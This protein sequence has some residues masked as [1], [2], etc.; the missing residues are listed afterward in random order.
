MSTIT[1]LYR[2]RQASSVASCTPQA[3]V[4]INC[5]MLEC[6]CRPRFFAGQVLQADDLNRL[7]AY[8]RA[9]NRL[10]N[11]QL[12]GWGVVNG[13]EV[14]CNPCG[15]GVTV[16]C[17]YALSPCGEDIVV[18]DAVTVDICSLIA[19][20][21]DAERQMFA[22]D[23]SGNN[24]NAQQGCNAA[25]EDWVLAIRYSESPARGVK[26]L[27]S[28]SS[29]CGCGS[30]NS[31]AT[32]A[33]GCGGSSGSSTGGCS[34][35]GST[36]STC[37]C[38]STKPRNAPVQCE[39]TVIC[40]G[41][42]F[43][44]YRLPPERTQRDQ[45]GGRSAIATNAT[46]AAASPIVQRFEC[47]AQTLLDNVA[48]KPT[49]SLKSD[50]GAW[51]LWGLRLKQYL[52]KYLQSKPG[53]NCSLNATLGALSIPDP[54]IDPAGFEQA[55]QTLMV[56][57]ID[58]LLACICSALLPPCPEP[59]PDVRVPIALVHVS[60]NPCSVLRV[61]NW[62]T[63]RKFATTFPSLQYW[64][65][66]LPFG[67]DLRELLQ[68]LCC[69]DLA[70]QLPQPVDPATGARDSLLFRAAA[71]RTAPP[72]PGAAAAGGA[73]P[74]AG[75]AAAGAAGTSGT[76]GTSGKTLTD[77][78]TLRLNPTLNDP[79][80]I[81][82][83]TSLLAGTLFSQAQPLTAETLF[84]SLT[85]QKASAAGQAGL[86]TQQVTY[87]PQF[88]AIQELVKPLVEATGAPMLTRT[89]TA[90]MASASAVAPAPAPAAS[91]SSTDFESV[92]AELASL[93]QTVSAQTDEI[94]Q[95]KARRGG[96]R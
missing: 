33:C 30:S 2:K 56:V 20:C 5:G 42:A 26:P 82:D 38:G 23:P 63:H 71:A 18:C 60:S 84:N 69:F 90:A 27:Y 4:C 59:S 92:R 13:L 68:T 93:K 50:P 15:D 74:N 35:G 37:T 51:Y 36:G 87:L 57:L 88:L 83:M 28:T 40:E 7:E 47:C 6:V 1:D 75:A 14:T 76:S 46:A 55:L 78:M 48:Q 9:K 45:A 72:A 61:C 16:S 12:N 66:I 64:L 89:L 11:R 39:P 65:G 86:S 80:S 58:A 32:G 81:Q 8:I 25:E 67:R 85:G 52:Q 79:S 41:F 24:T 31:S 62:T 44:V 91:P 96:K 54:R 19:R 77:R 49:A 94:N 73:G 21:K 17:G 34:C 10:H 43:E 3:P 95:L 70:G 22:C 53:Y 29:G